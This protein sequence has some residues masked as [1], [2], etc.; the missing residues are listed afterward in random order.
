MEIVTFFRRYEMILKS[1]P[2]P[3]KINFLVSRCVM[4]IYQRP[5]MNIFI[6]HHKYALIKNLKTE[7][8]NIVHFIIRLCILCVLSQM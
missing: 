6:M 7:N 2:I 8:M 1:T 3:S 4:Y 5:M